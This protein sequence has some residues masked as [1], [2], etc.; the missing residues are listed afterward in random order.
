MKFLQMEQS[1]RNGS[2]CHL[3]GYPLDFNPVHIGGTLKAISRLLHLFLRDEM[4]QFSLRE[5]QKVK[6][7]ELSQAAST[8]MSLPFSNLP[9]IFP[10]LKNRGNI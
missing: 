9:E 6:K 3:R 5:T 10:T 2:D 8:E 7:W 1:F 4:S